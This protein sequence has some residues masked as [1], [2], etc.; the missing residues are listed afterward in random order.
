L[1]G[2]G[3]ANLSIEQ[4]QGKVIAYLKEHF[5]NEK[6]VYPSDVADVL[7]L[8]YCVVRQVFD[9]LEKAGMVHEV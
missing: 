6:Q 1:N 7:G 4:V 5:K 8:D 2:L 3:L 9:V